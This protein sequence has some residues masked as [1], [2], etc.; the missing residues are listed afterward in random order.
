METCEYITQ[1]PL[2]PACSAPMDTA[3]I[4]I[5]NA[6]VERATASTWKYICMRHRQESKHDVL[7]DP[8]APCLHVDPIADEV[9]IE[10]NI[11]KRFDGKPVTAGSFSSNPGTE[12]LRTM[13]KS[14]SSGADVGTSE[15]RVVVAD[16]PAEE[17]T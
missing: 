14:S 7:A 17:N 12:F 15:V 11:F 10:H 16:P 2:C 9:P 13:G 5:N 6:V 1:Y 4:C 3:H 8:T